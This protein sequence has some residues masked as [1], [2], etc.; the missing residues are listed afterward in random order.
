MRSVLLGT[1]SDNVVI[2]K[3]FP[4][5][6]SGYPFT[7][8]NVS[9]QTDVVPIEVD[10][11]RAMNESLFSYS[12]GISI[13]NR[14]TPRYD[15]ID[16]TLWQWLCPPRLRGARLLLSNRETYAYEL[17]KALNDPISE[18]IDEALYK[19]GNLIKTA[20]DYLYTFRATMPGVQFTHD[21]DEMGML[22]VRADAWISIKLKEV[23]IERP[24][25]RGMHMQFIKMIFLLLCQQKS[26]LDEM[27][28]DLYHSRTLSLNA[29]RRRNGYRKYPWLGWFSPLAN[30]P[31]P[32]RA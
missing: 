22:I 5:F 13:D 11:A 8:D 25:F 15:Q 4:V 31:E 14:H 30:R 19:H 17:L 6:Y 26:F 10:L 3:E 23:L 28:S 12:P 32:S 7:D 20:V 21:K 29:R 16:A 9:T 27:S 18:T 24:N 1:D 2:T